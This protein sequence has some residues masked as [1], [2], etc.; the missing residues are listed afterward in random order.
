[1]K[2]LLLLFAFPLIISTA[3]QAQCPF[4]I[5]HN[6][7][8]CYAQC[9]GFVNIINE[10]GV[11]PFTYQW[12]N[13]PQTSFMNELCPGTYYVT[14]T[15]SVGCVAIDSVT[16]TQW[17]E[18]FFAVDSIHNVTCYGLSN[19]EAWTHASGGTPPY[20]F[21]WYN[22]QDSSYASGLMAVEFYPEVIDSKGCV[23][24]TFINITSPPEII[25][26]EMI[27]PTYCSN[28]VGYINLYPS[29]GT[30]YTFSAPYT[31]QWSTISNPNFSTLEQIYSLSP[32]I[33]TVT[34]TDSI[35]CTTIKTFELNSTDGPVPAVSWQNVTCFGAAN[36][37]VV[38]VDITGGSGTYSFLWN[39]GET[40]QVNPNPL[41][42]G[43]YWIKVTDDLM[44]CS[45]YDYF[46]VTE[47]TA[48]TD[49]PE[50]FNNVC[51]G[52]S[53]GYLYLM[54]T[55]G[56]PDQI[57]PFY[58]FE[59]NDG[60]SL[61]FKNKLVNGTYSVTITDIQG[62][63]LTESFL[64]T[65]P[66]KVIVDSVV[67]HNIS[68]YG[69]NDGSLEVFLSGGIP[70]YEYS[71]DSI[72]WDIYNNIEWLYPAVPY[73][74]FA[75]DSN[76][77]HVNTSY[78]TLTEPPIIDLPYF[79]IDPTCVG[80]NGS[81]EITPSGGVPPYT[82]VWDTPPLTGFIETGLTQGQ[83]NA[84]VTD[85]NNCQ[86]PLFFELIQYSVPAVLTGANY[87][88][89]GPVPPN[90]LEIFLFRPAY[91]GA[92]QMDTVAVT[93]N[94]A[95][96]WQFNNLLPGIYFV[97]ADLINPASYPTILSSYYD[98]KYL[99]LD[100]DTIYLSCD[101]TLQINF[102]MYEIAPDTTGTGSVSGTVIMLPPPKSGRA[103]GE[104]VPGAEILI[105][106]EPNDVPVQCTFTD[107]AGF[108]QFTGLD[109]GSGYHLI[110]DIPGFPLLSTY[111]NIVV[112]GNDTVPN[113]NFVVD[114]TSTD[115][116]I[117]MDTASYVSV[118][119][120][121]GINAEIYPNPFTSSV[122]VKIKLDHSIPVSS[123]LFDALGRKIQSLDSGIL[124]AGEH[125]FKVVP[126]T[127]IQGSCY[128]IIHAGKANII[129]K[130]I[131][132]QK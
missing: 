78:Y 10:T 62:C 1:M 131:S 32:D 39:T 5:E 110:V 48:I 27:N 44:S 17:P 35:G 109:A 80:N 67:T 121:D 25:T 26:N 77:C 118:I 53:L 8:L 98:S 119:S 79:Q 40:V 11:P 66:T 112:T 128:L 18:I 97:K 106:Q 89:G 104:P 74:V 56:S 130:L 117:Y 7:P 58:H 81:I 14:V 41:V 64:I 4:T 2:R 101:D 15:D 107:T 99:W 42:P 124:N 31:Y 33:Y 71:L 30:P 70:P 36:G 46:T 50:Q 73:H 22:G 92:A 38:T 54:P 123:E 61:E 103:V 13:G 3:L 51:F 57:P 6:G 95:S 132:I 91:T 102:N 43:N 60:D 100:A 88:S 23:V 69:M 55:G 125:E 82:I 115:G 47:P 96:I 108:Y 126:Q 120:L 45:G 37:Q 86:N 127:R 111:E 76:F 94:S 24:S 87:Y 20:T 28:A 21:N 75:K 19:G 113:L 90:E 84:T 68:C 63:T 122:N 93:T 49:A 52:D 16:F 83:Y 72:T 129:K 34:V 85:A 116:G 29:G 105:E 59:W 65:S 9:N 114:S 12:S